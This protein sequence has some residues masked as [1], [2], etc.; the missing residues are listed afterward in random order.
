MRNFI[1]LISLICITLVQPFK[2]LSQELNCNVT[3]IPPR[4]ITGDAEVF[5]TMEGVI[6]EFINNR[7]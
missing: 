4:V 1:I 7:K 3:I 6:E 2:A 5:K